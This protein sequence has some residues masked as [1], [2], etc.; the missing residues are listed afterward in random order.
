MYVYAKTLSRRLELSNTVSEGLRQV[1][2]F[3]SNH[4]DKYRGLSA[5]ALLRSVGSSFVAYVVTHCANSSR[6]NINDHT[7]RSGSS[8]TLC[9]RLERGI[10]GLT[11]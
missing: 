7:Q 2:A 11:L 10:G 5:A 4:G 1:S 8:N 9:E 6:Y 3:E